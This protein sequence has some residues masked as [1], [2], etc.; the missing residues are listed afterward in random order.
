MQ[1]I[2]YIK[3]NRSG[4]IDFVS[5]NIA[6]GLIE[7]GEAVLMTVRMVDAMQDKMMRAETKIQA[8]MDRA[9]QTY[10]IKSFKSE[11]E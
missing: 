10:E 4:Q 3:G 9:K 1:R 5:N 2:Q 8:K 11:S 7:R 6:H